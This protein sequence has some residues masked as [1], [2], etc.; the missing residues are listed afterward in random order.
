MSTR[1]SLL[2]GLSVAVVLLIATLLPAVLLPRPVALEFLS[3]L[4]FGIATVYFGFAVSDGRW[5][6][7]VFQVCAM[8]VFFAL[9]FLGLWLA[10]LFLAAGY[11]GHGVWDA[12]HHPKIQLVKTTVP[13][14]YIYG[15]IVY[16]WIIGG[17]VLVWWVLS[18]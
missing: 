18:A 17:F 7:G 3:M 6:E 10:P 11:F 5:R 1:K 15:C 16:D 14:W 12:A 4:L 8:T 9:T 13:E 2:I